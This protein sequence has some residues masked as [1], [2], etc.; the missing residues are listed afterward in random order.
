MK[1]LAA[2][3]F[4][5]LL[6]P[7]A[8]ADT[9]A[10]SPVTDPP[11]KEAP[12]PSPVTD[13]PSK[14]A[15]A[16]SPATD[17]PSKGAPAPAPV[18]GLPSTEPPAPAAMPLPAYPA[19]PVREVRETL[20]GENVV[21]PYR[22]L[23][24][25]TSPESRAFLRAQDDYARGML[26]RIP[27]R[28]ALARRI[29]DLSSQQVIVRDL[30]IASGKVFYLKLAAGSDAPVLCVRD[31]F[32]GA[33]RVLA[34]P[35]RF[36]SPSARA[37]IDWYRPSP[38]GRLVAY[39]VSVNGSGDATLRVLEARDGRDAG[40]K[41]ERARFN[42][43]L[44]WHHDSRAFYYA[45][46]PEGG[47]ADPAHR[48]AG[49]RL[50]RHVVGRPAAQDEIVFASGL[51]GA[52]DVPEFA[53][54]SLVVPEDSV[55]A[56]A[57]VRH[58]EGR[59]LSV[60]LTTVRDLAKGLPRWTKI[61]DEDDGVTAIEAWKD[62]LYLLTHKDAPRNKVMVVRAGKD[63]VSRPRPAV[64]EGEAVI[65]GMALAADALYLRITVGGL[66]RLE[67]LNLGPGASRKP[68]FVK[69][70]FD[71]AIAQMLTHPRRPGAILR[72]QGFIEPPSI[73]TV[74]A[75]SGDLRN[76]GL[77][78][79]P[80]ADFSAM[81]E[82]RLYATSHDG[83]KIPVTLLY[84]KTTMLTADNPTLLL[85]FGAYGVS[86]VPVFDATRLAWLERGGIIAIA[87]IRGGG[88]YGEEWHRAGRKSRKE[89]TIL[90]FIACAEFLVKYGFT[91]PKRL[92]IQGTSAGGI[93][94]AGAAVRRPDLFAAAVPRVAALDMLRFEFA[95]GG[96]PSIPEFGSIATLEGFHD[97]RRMS[98]Y[99]QVKDGTAYPAVLLTTG[100]NDSRVEP[101]QAA[102]MAARLQAAS[103]GGKPVLLR[104][105]WEG[106]DGDAEARSQR[107]EELADIYAFLLWQFG[108]ADF[109]PTPPAPPAAAPP[110]PA[111]PATL[112]PAAP[113]AL[114]PAPGIPPPQ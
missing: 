110:A 60:H 33:E 87:H 59:D 74:E 49:V 65:L 50:Y 63:G 100:M 26:A 40:V 99:H 106:G 78:P 32:A 6:P 113:P 64:P 92:A 84:R 38:D 35:A 97:L 57:V 19:A 103:V 25:A 79:A 101:W 30:A 86:Q 24:D 98:A 43:G 95:P 16:P 107:D 4:A 17:P 41:I 109:A 104:V 1:I 53:F 61:V 82:V 112:P 90:D 8:R 9:P 15:P 48:Y 10:P 62:D 91:S 18:T 3:L 66:E 81:D 29:H 11:S 94:S 14:E 58:G 36:S 52:R 111:L 42:A 22:W 34:D 2:L 89:N 67:R 56:Y 37:S 114:S 68:E 21:D 28:A 105:E 55:H 80:R 27:G 51:G 7:A 45:R 70:A 5:A 77:Q 93:P 13:P 75:K 71:V 44:S 83:T 88:E 47:P 46:I 31:G 85:G 108:D 12:A 20:H 73:V 76:T 54:P 72:L 39:G 96:P 102:K 69:T 23:E